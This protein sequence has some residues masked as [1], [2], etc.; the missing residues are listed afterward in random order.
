M[1]REKSCPLPNVSYSC[2]SR[3]KILRRTSDAEKLMI[4][5]RKR[6]GHRCATAAM[7]VLIVAWD[8]LDPSLSGLAYQRNCEILPLNAEPTERRCGINAT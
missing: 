4:V 7:T 5:Y 6:P 1:T 8:G 2:S 3:A